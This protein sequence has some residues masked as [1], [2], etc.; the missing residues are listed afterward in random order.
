MRAPKGWIIAGAAPE[1][2]EVV[3][4]AS[5]RGAGVACTLRATRE[6]PR[7]FGTLMQ[8]FAP[9]GLRGRRV[10]LSAWLRSDGVR[11]RCGLW[12]RVDGAG[13]QTLTM[14]NMAARPVS[15]TT[16]WGRYDVVLDV[17][18]E[19]ELLAFGILLDGA[20][21]A[22]VEGVALEEVGE[23]VPTTDPRYP[24]PRAPRN[25]DFTEG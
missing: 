2:Y 8:D 20:G 4:S 5:D 10:R 25:L 15:G 3:T 7:G 6:S 14:D 16:P 12:M 1:D 17:A 22:T 24:T 9:D 11:G 21:S 19:A 18:A 13:R 23:E